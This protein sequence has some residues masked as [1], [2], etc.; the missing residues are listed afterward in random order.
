MFSKNTGP[1]SINNCSDTSNYFRVITELAYEKCRK[2]DMLEL[3]P[4]LQIGQQLCHPHYCKIVEVN[5]GQ[6]KPKKKTKNFSKKKILE[7]TEPL[8]NCNNNAG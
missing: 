1:C 5:R 7:P 4:Y 8:D 6:R 2:N 3:Y